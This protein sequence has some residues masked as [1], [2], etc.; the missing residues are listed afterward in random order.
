MKKRG[1]HGFKLNETNVGEIKWLLQNT[2]LK[3]KEIAKIY[4]V[5]ASHISEISNGYKWD[6]IYSKKPKN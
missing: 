2:K 4:N 3:K 5:V 6:N 1:K